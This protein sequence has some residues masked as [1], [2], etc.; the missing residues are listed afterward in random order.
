VFF[1]KL[2]HNKTE[3]IMHHYFSKVGVQLMQ[4][5]GALEK[6]EKINLTQVLS[7]ARSL[8]PLTSVGPHWILQD[9]HIKC[10]HFVNND[11]LKMYDKG[12]LS[13]CTTNPGQF[14]NQIDNLLYNSKQCC[15]GL[16]KIFLDESESVTP[17]ENIPLA[18][19]L[20]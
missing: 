3:V 4:E 6:K 16:A 19:F 13:W 5:N 20:T 10:Y 14:H 9:M 15:I 17:V 18:A 11:V 1:A 8:L 7:V 12:F 2:Q